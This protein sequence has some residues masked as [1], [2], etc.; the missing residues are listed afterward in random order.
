LEVWEKVLVDLGLWEEDEHSRWECQDCH[1]G[2]YDMDVEIL[3]MDAKYAAHEGVV[4]D[5]SEDAEYNCGDCHEEI[6]ENQQFTLHNSL[7][8]YDTVLYERSLPENHETIEAGEARHC[9]G[10]HTTCGQCHVSQP[11]SVG[12]GLI[13]GHSFK[14]TPS[15]SRQC[16]ACH[17]SRVKNEY[18]GAHEELQADVHLR[19]RMLCTEC[20]T[21]GELHGTDFVDTEEGFPT[22]RYDGEQGPACESCHEIALGA[23]SENDYHEAHAT[24]TMSCQTCHSTSYMNCYGCHLERTDDEYDLAYFNLEHEELGFFIGQNPIQSEER[25]YRYVPV[26]HIPTWPG[27]FDGYGDDALPNFEN[28]PTWTYA[29]P[30]NIQVNTPQT[31]SCD[32][33]HGN[34]LYFLTADKV[35]EEELGQNESVIVP[36]APVMPD[37]DG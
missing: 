25:P 27:L 14:A 6:A 34:D 26:R 1:G 29:T 2:P 7:E 3:D 12:G 9:N 4:R 32:T 20:H 5:P 31:E 23:D 15:M 35:L 19:A 21:A 8:G 36:S 16:T 24:D 11:T 37:T 17:G 10:C 33:C 13:D 22:H 28:L 18:T 30:H